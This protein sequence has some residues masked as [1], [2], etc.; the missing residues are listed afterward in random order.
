[1][2]CWQEAGLPED[3]TVSDIDL[4]LARLA[5]DAEQKRAA[6]EVEN[7]R[8]RFERDKYRDEAHLL[9]N[10]RDQALYLLEREQG[11]GARTPPRQGRTVIPIFVRRP[12]RRRF[13]CVECGGLLLRRYRRTPLHKWC[14]WAIEAGIN[15]G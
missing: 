11:R 3:E 13:R 5:A 2:A 8:L 1:V 14:W 9:T 10:E 7:E 6:L 12:R 4:S 15:D